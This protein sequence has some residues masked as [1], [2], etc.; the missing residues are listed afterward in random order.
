MH[1]RAPRRA[2][3]LLAALCLLGV[4]AACSGLP[5]KAT[6]AGPVQGEGV[7][8]SEDRTTDDF[9]H[10][11]AAA[12]M[13]VTVTSGSPASVTVAAQPNLLPLISTEVVDGQL[14]VNV[15]PPGLSSTEPVTLTVVVPD[16]RSI[17]LSGGATGTFDVLGSELAVDVSAGAQLTGTG[18]TRSLTVTA[19][20]GGQADLGGLVADTAVIDLT[21]GSQA[22]LTVVTALTGSADGG[23]TLR[24]TQTPASLD[25]KTSGGATVQGG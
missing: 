14:I 1:R 10:L 4:A 23:S 12:G 2:V 24:L 16:L 5:P 22:D 13:Q 17:T 18:R 21:G 15:A 20:S 3:P 11:S 8:A 19:S 7:V 9:Q 6:P 25:V